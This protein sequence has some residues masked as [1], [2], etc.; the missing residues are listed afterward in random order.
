MVIYLITPF[1]HGRVYIGKALFQHLEGIVDPS[2]K[3]STRGIDFILDG[4][5]RKI[6]QVQYMQSKTWPSKYQLLFAVNVNV[7]DEICVGKMI[8]RR[9]CSICFE[10]FNITDINTD[11]GF[12]MPPKLPEPYPC[13]RCNMDNGDWIVRSDDTSEDVMFKR[14]QEYHSETAPI[15][16][17][18][19]DQG[20]L[21][22][23]TPFCGVD[24]IHLLEQLVELQL[25]D[26]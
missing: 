7:P 20:M 3:I 18:Y 2:I 26:N 13:E 9:K 17:H 12:V 11:D 1:L 8:G 16:Q 6:T 14:I 21:V 24:D 23:F 5:P 22:K 4:F 25:K 19:E 15:L 10:S